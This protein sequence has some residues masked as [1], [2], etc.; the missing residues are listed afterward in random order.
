M[1]VKCDT[2]LSLFEQDDELAA[3]SET[4]NQMKEQLLEKQQEL[5]QL[6]RDM[7]VQQ[8]DLLRVTK[9]WDASKSENK[10][11]MQALE[12]LALQYEQTKT[13]VG[14]KIAELD[15]LSEDNAKNRVGFVF[16]SST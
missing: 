11:I 7:D 16:C 2:V 9:D 12:E 3:Q 10:E 4:I 13:D 5:L 14:K 1:S 8:M 6:R 15:Q